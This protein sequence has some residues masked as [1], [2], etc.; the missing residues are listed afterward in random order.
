MDLTAEKYRYFYIC[1][2]SYHTNSGDGM[3]NARDDVPQNK[4]AASDMLE[5]ALHH[6]DN[7]IDNAGRRN[8]WYC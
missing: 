4:R 7:I 8:V 3:T 2:M 1:G 5:D 6:F